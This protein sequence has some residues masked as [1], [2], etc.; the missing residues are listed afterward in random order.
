MTPAIDEDIVPDG[1]MLGVFDTN[2]CLEDHSRSNLDVE[3]HGIVSQIQLT[4]GCPL[5]MG[6]EPSIVVLQISACGIS[7]VCLRCKLFMPNK[8]S[9]TQS[10]TMLPM[11][12]RVLRRPLEPEERLAL[13]GNSAGSIS[14]E[15][16]DELARAWEELDGEEREALQ[17]LIQALIRQKMATRMDS[18][19]AGS[20]HRFLDRLGKTVDRFNRFLR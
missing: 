5:G 11:S 7:H 20:T 12:A 2:R 9:S 10:S 4:P 16:L 1:V 3:Y 19:P 8:I 15:K 14:L 13:W 17:A 6:Y 18:P